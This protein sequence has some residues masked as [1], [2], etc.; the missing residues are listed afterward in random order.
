[1]EWKG[2]LNW[3]M[4]Y[5]DGTRPS[6]FKQMDEE[7]KN[8]LKEALDSMVVDQTKVMINGCKILKEIEDI[9]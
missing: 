4:Q 5:T 9:L 6:E 3:S 8:W 1:M 2:L 7:T